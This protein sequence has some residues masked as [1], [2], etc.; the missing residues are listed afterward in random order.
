[1]SGGAG[2]DV[3]IVDSAGDKVS[4]FAGTDTILLR[5]GSINLGGSF[6]EN[7]TGDIAGLAFSITGDVVA[8]VLTGGALADTINGGLGND[9]LI[10][11]AGND[12]L[13]G[14]TG[15]DQ[16]IFNAALGAANV[17]TIQ[18]YTVSDD[19]ILLDRTI[20]TAF[21]SSGTLAVGAFKAGAAAT[22]A[23]DRI[24]YNSVTGALLYDADGVGG[25]AAVQFATLTG[26]P[27]TGAPVLNY[28]EFLII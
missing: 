8:N 22:D 16:F 15:L 6:I 18:G 17:D 23:D 12:S 5:T 10:G 20:F 28:T 26:A 13:I 3:F 1:M 2:N 14:G 7:V 21:G 24:I 9:T 4:D 25:T 11:G 27:V 19:T